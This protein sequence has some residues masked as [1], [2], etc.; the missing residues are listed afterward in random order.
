[1]DA[2]PFLASS[3]AMVGMGVISLLAKMPCMSITIGQESVAV[4]KLLG[5]VMV[6]SNPPCGP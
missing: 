1:M 6:M 5:S 3:L 2:I 4:L